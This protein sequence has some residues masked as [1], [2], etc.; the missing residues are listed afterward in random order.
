MKTYGL[1]M[2]LNPFHSGHKYF[3][4]QVKEL[5]NPKRIIAVISTQTVQRGEFGILDTTAKTKRLLSIGVDVVIAMPLIYSNQGGKHFAFHAIEILNE[6]GIDE[7][8][9]GSESGN[10]KKIKN[11]AQQLKKETEQI[12]NKNDN[13][14]FVS[15]KEKIKTKFNK[16]YFKEELENFESND[17]L[18]LSYYR[19][20]QEINPEIK[21][22]LIKRNK[23]NIK[24][25]ENFLSATKIRGIFFVLNKKQNQLPVEFQNI[26]EP[27][28]YEQVKLI[29][30][31]QILNLLKYQLITMPQNQ[32]KKIFLSE[33]GQLIT[34]IE[35][36]IKNYK[37]IKTVQELIEKAKDKNNSK[38]KIQRI[39]LNV[40]LQITSEEYFQNSE[41]K[42]YYILGFNSKVS[43]E[44]KNKKNF[45]TNFKKSQKLYMMDIKLYNLTRNLK[46]T[47]F[48]FEKKKAEINLI[49]IDGQQMNLNKNLWNFSEIKK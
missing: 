21:L 14:N 26:I 39:I 28:I 34:K 27:E 24:T 13:K 6:Y 43:K 15:E 33:N 1:I 9:C 19:A 48:I 44:I 11:K 16:G 25:N 47:K 20:I 5:K 29:D 31:K 2:E 17:I 22:S 45:F 46:H 4:E 30:Q 3:L 40:L 42:C 12:K 8:I 36:I 37:E 35:N 32:K 38:Y 23:K 7:L 18:A 49:E 10:F 41:H